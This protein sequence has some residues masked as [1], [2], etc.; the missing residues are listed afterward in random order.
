MNIYKY[1][2]GAQKR[3]E[4]EEANAKKA[5][6]PK[7]TTFFGPKASTSSQSKSK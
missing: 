1:K 3:K 2:S 4:L 5:K 6:L 7:I